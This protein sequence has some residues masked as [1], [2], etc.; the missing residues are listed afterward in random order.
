MPKNTC[1]AFSPDGFKGNLSLLDILFH[2]PKNTCYFPL[3]V[4]RESISIGDMFLLFF[5]GTEEN[6]R[7][8]HYLESPRPVKHGVMTVFFGVVR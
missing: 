8:N 1:F 5:Q 6:G 3:L 7:L 2:L 4:E